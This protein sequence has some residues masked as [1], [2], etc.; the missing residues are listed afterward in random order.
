MPMTEATIPASSPSMTFQPESP[1]SQSPTPLQS[2]SG[3]RS[4]YL[5]ALIV[6]GV[7]GGVLFIVV[8]GLLIYISRK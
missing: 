2:T 3:G 5:T 4:D 1:S 7:A 6:I 8:I